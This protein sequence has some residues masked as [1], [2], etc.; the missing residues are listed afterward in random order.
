[1]TMN[2]IIRPVQASDAQAISEMLNAII[3]T[4]KYTILE[5][6]ISVE[7]QREFIESFSQ[8]GVFFV[9]ERLH[10]QKLLGLQDISPAS[11]WSNAMR[12]VG[13]ISTFITMDAQGQGIGRKLAEV[14][15]A[16][17]QAKGFEKVTAMIRGDNPRA[18]AFYVGQ[19]FTIV[20]TM[21][22]HAVVNGQ[23]VD[24]VIAEKMLV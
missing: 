7:M 22:R 10:D 1:M 15:L 8:R 21:R 16:A 2:F 18:I 4:G 9:A 12:H 3:A 20:G 17:A 13:E 6:P 24:E 23:Y 11:S 14:T 19:G 5:G